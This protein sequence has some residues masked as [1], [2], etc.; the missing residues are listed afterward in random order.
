[1]SIKLKHSGG[2]SVSLNPPTSAPTSSDVAFKLPTSDGSAGQVLKTDGSGNLSWVT[3]GTATTNGITHASTWY[4][5]S[6]FAGTTNPVTSLAPYTSAGAGTLGAA[7]SINSTT[8]YFTF[9]VTGIWDISLDVGFNIDGD[10]RYNRGEIRTTTDDGS[11]SAIAS[12][13]YT[14]ID[15]VGY[16]GAGYAMT[17]TNHIF[18]CQATSTHKCKFAVETLSGSVNI[19]MMKIK[20]IR[21]GDT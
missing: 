1:M 5:T 18:D 3:P 20:F 17:H 6:A 10:S 21:L 19:W 2:N 8:G 13:A 9:P 15:D 16:N 4:L 7:L 11:N 14:F 12:S